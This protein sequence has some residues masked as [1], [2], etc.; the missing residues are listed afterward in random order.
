VRRAARTPGPGGPAAWNAD[1]QPG[2]CDV[3]ADERPDR[4]EHGAHHRG[5]A[6][7]RDLKP[8]AARPPIARR[9]RLARAHVTNSSSVA[10]TYTITFQD[11]AG[12]DYDFASLL[13]FVDSNASASAIRRDDAV[14]RRHLVLLPGAPQL[15]S[16]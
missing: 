15:W 6:D 1:R 13:L 10:D 3:H 5:G 12:D 7:R 4:V 14:E 2:E 8:I 16:A 9:D 11:V